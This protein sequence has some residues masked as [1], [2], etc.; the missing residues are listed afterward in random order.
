MNIFSSKKK[1]KEKKEAQV[2]DAIKRISA[3]EELLNKKSQ[4]LEEKIDEEAQNSKKFVK[5]NKKLAIKALKA[6]KRFEKQL[7]QID[8]TLTTLEYQRESLLEIRQSSDI[9]IVMSDAAKAMKNIYGDLTVD[10]VEDLKD[11]IAEQKYLSDEIVNAI[12][13]Q[14]GMEQFDEDELMNELEELEADE[15]HNRLDEL[16][17]VSKTPLDKEVSKEHDKEADMV[18][19]SHWGDTFIV[20]F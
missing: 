20:I 8:G 16:P 7:F 6:K 9:L 19:I 15:A 17:D 12:S 4:F 5:T 1:E 10:K 3:M 11:E 18:Q 14:N 13:Q 2:E